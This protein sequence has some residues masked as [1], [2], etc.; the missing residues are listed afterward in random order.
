[1]SEILKYLASVF[2]KFHGGGAVFAKLFRD[3]KFLPLSREKNLVKPSQVLLDGDAFPE[4]Q[5]L[6]PHFVTVENL[7]GQL[8]KCSKELRSLGALDEVTLEVVNTIMSRYERGQ[9]IEDDERER[10]LVKTCL[11]ESMSHKHL[12]LIQLHNSLINLRNMK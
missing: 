6:S 4:V 12:L 7:H 1:M 11:Q 2:G 9:D 8:T 10:I 3:K 5:E